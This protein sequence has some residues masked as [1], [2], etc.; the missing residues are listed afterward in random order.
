MSHTGKLYLIPVPISS[1]PVFANIPPYNAEVVSRLR[2][3]IAEDAKTARRSLKSFNYPSIAEAEISLLNEHSMPGEEHKLLEPLLAGHDVG[4]MSDAGCPGVAD[5]G[6]A[7]VRLAHSRAVQVIPLTGPSS[8][9]M[10]VMASGFTGQNFAFVGYLPVEKGPRQ[11]RLREL[12]SLASRSRQAQFFIE[13]PYRN[14]QLLET[15][16]ATL[17]GSTF[18]FIGR[19]IT[20]DAEFLRSRTVR[21]WKTAR[22]PQLH[23]MP[24]VFGIFV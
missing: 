3:F 16:I 19:D 9:L 1:A 20:G 17:S 4:L 13:T 22:P 15:I 7:V 5:P 2:F 10:S 14:E 24:V 12:E 18:L 21:E 11:A 8:I 23:K 6:A